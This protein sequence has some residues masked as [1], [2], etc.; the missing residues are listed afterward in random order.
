[1]FEV[2]SARVRPDLYLMKCKGYEAAPVPACPLPAPGAGGGERSG[3]GLAGC[4]GRRGT[5]A[6]LCAAPG[7]GSLRKGG[8]HRAPAHAPDICERSNAIRKLDYRDAARLR[9]PRVFVPRKMAPG[10]GQRD[11]AC[12]PPS[13]GGG[14]T[15]A[16]LSRGNLISAA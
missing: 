16:D 9:E 13:K 3:A 7:E 1:M 8:C 6:G 10:S 12:A 15:S 2:R 4:A 11:L 5:A 14:E